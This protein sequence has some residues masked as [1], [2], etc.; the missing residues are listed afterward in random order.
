MTIRSATH[1]LAFHAAFSA[2]AD[3]WMHLCPAGEFH[4]DD[5]RGPYLLEA[6][7]EVIARSMKAG[8]LVLDECH[9]TDLAAPNGQPAPARGWIVEMQARPDG[10]WGR[11]ELTPSGKQLMSEDAYRGISPVFTSSRTSPHRIDQ[12]L[13]AS[14]TNDPNL[15][16]TTLHSKGQHS[17][18]PE[19]LKRLGLQP[20]A[21]EDAIAAA[22]GKSLD[23]VETHAKT[24]AAL[25]TV[26]GANANATGDE[27]VIHLQSVKKQAELAGDTKKMAETIVELQG[28]LD[29]SI[30]NTAKTA[31]TAFVDGAIKDGK[32]IKALRD[33][34]ITRH[35][36]DPAAVETEVNAMQ[37]VHSGAVTPSRD[38]KIATAAGSDDPNEIVRKA[39]LHQ[40]EHGGTYVDAVLAVTGR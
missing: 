35:Q 29:T 16:L 33:H 30:N 26:S 19:L 40:K 15:P 2:D 38:T 8:K 13:R 4:G 36:K 28:R 37:S 34:Y 24:I 17:M 23:Q 20:D 7:D 11:V 10:I 1:F 39:Q 12:I 18:T 14:L 25:A 27:L 5:G 3:T 32:P 21:T 22:I 9:S 31:A 6:P